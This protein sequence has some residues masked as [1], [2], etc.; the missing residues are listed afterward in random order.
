[1]RLDDT[2]RSARGQALRF[3]GKTQRFSTI[4]NDSREPGDEPFKPPD[5][6]AL[7][8]FR[9]RMELQLNRRPD[10]TPWTRP[11]SAGGGA[12][13][14]RIPHPPAEASGTRLACTERGVCAE[15]PPL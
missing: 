8:R 5:V 1:M 11:R 9:W 4:L 12:H 13:Y 15:A 7:F 2:G 10:P 14:A 6:L 3:I